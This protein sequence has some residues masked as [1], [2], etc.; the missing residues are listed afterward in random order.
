[1]TA[2]AQKMPRTVSVDERRSAWRRSGLLF[3][4]ATALLFALYF[5]TVAA[6][7]E[8]WMTSDTYGYGFLILPLSFYRA[9][10]R[11]RQLALV[12]PQPCIW[13]L[14]WM[15][16]A[17]LLHLVGSIASIMLFQ[18]L[19]FV[20]L[21]QGLFAL[22]M[23]WPVVRQMLFPVVFLFFAV[24][25]GAE[26]VPLL[27]T[28]TADITVY[29]LRTSG[30]PTF[31]S[32]VYIEIPTGSFVVAEVCSGV[33]FLIT[34]LVLGTLA[35]HLFFRSWRRRGLFMLLCL[36]VPILA[37]GL[38][39]YGIIMLAHLID[40]RLALSVDHVVYGLIFLSLVL[41]ILTGLGALFR[42]RWPQAE[43]SMPVLPSVRTR[44]SSS[45][46]A[47][48]LAVLLLGAGKAW[49]RE[50]TAPPTAP[51]TVELAALRPG[52]D[53]SP[54]GQSLAGWDPTFPGA[55][56]QLLRTYQ[57]PD[58]EV[59]LFVAYYLYQRDG[60]EVIANQNSFAGKGRDKQVTRFERVEVDVANRRQVLRETLVQ[61]PK[62]PRL[63]WSWYEIGGTPTISPIAGKFFE[64][65]HTLS[66]G[67]RAA[68]A[69]AVS[70]VAGDDLRQTRAR[71]KAFLS[72]LEADQGL[73]VNL[74]RTNASQTA[75]KA[76]EQGSQ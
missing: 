9:F 42:D 76:P 51:G 47:F 21:W 29:L 67:S 22:L 37:N 46:G 62:G 65:W 20:A 3:V 1:M 64:I 41:L 40:Y 6:M 50:T 17:L 69:V 12:T 70:T 56:T 11:R 5:E 27:Q 74:P 38:R 68:S 23:G 25:V 55:D 34:S 60:H 24:P 13:A 48:L 43:T 35:A 63:V 33:R 36:V 52:S 8:I 66:G 4:L 49:T 18:Q 72:A 61:T 10:H 54:S 59:A 31:L 32:G 44:L 53:W 39:A 2:V 58:S 14:L 45:L 75:D 16:G 30:I 19:A 15:A 7:V 71:L 73:A 26:I 28:I 57:G